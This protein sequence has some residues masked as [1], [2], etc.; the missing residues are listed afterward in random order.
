MEHGWNHVELNENHKICFK[1]INF[2]NYAGK[3][4][5]N[6]FTYIKS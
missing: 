6:F 4:E 1:L 3:Q 2:I 5:H